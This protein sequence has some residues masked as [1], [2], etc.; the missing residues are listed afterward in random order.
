MAEMI[1]RGAAAIYEN[2]RWMQSDRVPFKELYP[3]AQSPYLD[4]ARAA[5]EAMREPTE[6]MIEAGA[7]ENGHQVLRSDLV[8]QVW[9]D[10]IDAAL[11]SKGSEQST[12]QGKGEAG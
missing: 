10:M 7:H 11:L 4:E 6:E 8:D 3:S 12:G 5:I 1:E 2:R 9:V